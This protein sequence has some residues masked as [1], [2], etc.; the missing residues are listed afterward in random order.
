MPRTLNIT[1]KV[2]FP[3][4]FTDFQVLHMLKIVLDA[5]QAE[6]QDHAIGGSQGA[7]DIASMHIG[8]PIVPLT[9]FW[10]A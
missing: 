6:A 5:G 10:D 2:T 3:D 7:Q 1:L 4:E 8:N 9:P